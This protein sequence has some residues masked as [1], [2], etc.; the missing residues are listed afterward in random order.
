MR[1]ARGALICLDA[2]ALVAL[3]SA[4]SG[5]SLVWNLFDSSSRIFPDLYEGNGLILHS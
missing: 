1:E 5:H 4:R 3:L 2:A